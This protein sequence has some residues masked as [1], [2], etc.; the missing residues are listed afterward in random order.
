[1]TLDFS[2]LVLAE[3]ID[4]L[5]NIGRDVSLL[6]AAG[7]VLG[8]G[9]LGWILAS[10]RAAAAERRV[11]E[12]DERI[13]GP[14]AREL[15]AELSRIITPYRK[16]AYGR[17]VEDRLPPERRFLRNLRVQLRLSRQRRQQIEAMH[18]QNLAECASLRDELESIRRA[19]DEAA[20]AIAQATSASVLERPAAESELPDPPTL[21][22][23][24][25]IEPP[26][27]TEPIEAAEVGD[28]S[29][30][31]TQ[32]ESPAIEPSLAETP[33][34]DSSDTSDDA[35]VADLVFSAL[36]DQTDDDSGAS[37]VE[38]ETAALIAEGNAGMDALTDS[39]EVD[40][41]IDFDSLLAESAAKL[42]VES[43]DDD[44]LGGV[45][46]FE[47]QL[48]DAGYGSDEESTS[49]PTN[50]IKS[51]A[52]DA[53]DDA[54]SPIPSP[55][56]E[57]S[58][59]DDV[60]A[61][62]KKKSMPD[63]LADI[64]DNDGVAN[65]P[66]AAELDEVM[67]ADGAIESVET[68]DAVETGEAD[69]A[70][71]DEPFG[72]LESIVAD[73]MADSA[74]K[75]LAAV[76]METPIADAIDQA[77]DNDAPTGNS[78]SDPNSD[79]PES[80]TQSATPDDSASVDIVNKAKIDI[81]AAVARADASRAALESLDA[82]L[83]ANLNHRRDM[84][85]RIDSALNERQIQLVTDI[86]RAEA[87]HLSLT[88]ALDQIRSSVDAIQGDLSAVIGDGLGANKP[89]QD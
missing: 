42:G 5:S 19:A 22:T 83:D 58:S 85:A 45:E 36:D 48:A 67:E 28:S 49:E 13:E 3:G 64:E 60:D 8:G 2:H 65:D 29:A 62:S 25:S 47:Q 30:P 52:T 15:C 89:S 33:A 73:E 10:R 38:D 82:S 26:V 23:I 43:L 77:A 50:E 59:P 31:P 86:L 87:E 16:G 69:S 37:T 78:V 88:E 12:L 81:D 57:A 20:A 55:E 53:E 34:A 51:E 68:P 11:D 21:P 80:V 75:S 39:A 41:A 56:P 79:T 54:T 71:P 40:E 46:A 1:M 61:D 6:I 24:E 4:L 76:E 14:S 27:S 32:P 44:S 74:A 18:A 70:A 63:A 17:P 35:D 66:V 72:E 7:V 9:L 84:I